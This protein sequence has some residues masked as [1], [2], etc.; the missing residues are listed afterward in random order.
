MFS[1]LA[2]REIATTIFVFLS[3]MFTDQQYFLKKR[4]HMLFSVGVDQFQ[5]SWPP[6]TPKKTDGRKKSATGG[7]L[8]RLPNQPRPRWFLPKNNCARLT[9]AGGVPTR[10]IHLS[11]LLRGERLVMEEGGGEN[12]AV[13]I[14]SCYSELMLYL[15]THTCTSVYKGVCSVFSRSVS[16]SVCI[17]V[18]LV[19]KQG[20][21]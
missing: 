9:C 5:S 13:V 12:W 3:T 19:S 4:S 17:C 15:C 1:F 10:C 2:N 6:P 7:F 20:G 8:V 16:V 21:C 14:K 11:R 18:W